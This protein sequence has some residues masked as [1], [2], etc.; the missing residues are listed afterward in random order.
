M[1]SGKCWYLTSQGIMKYAQLLSETLC[2][3][4]FSC[5]FTSFP[6][7]LSVSWKYDSPPVS[8][9]INT[10]RWCYCYVDRGQHWKKH[11]SWLRMGL[12]SCTLVHTTLKPSAIVWSSLF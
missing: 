11:H 9:N 10:A 6:R 3:L 4:I 12:C 5:N 1:F 8:Y 7:T 2:P